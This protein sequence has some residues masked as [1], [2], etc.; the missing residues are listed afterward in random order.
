MDGQE[1]RLA[2]ALTV[3]HAAATTLK[4]QRDVFDS[5]EWST[6]DRNQLTAAA[7]AVTRA[8]KHTGALVSKMVR[9][10][11]ELGAA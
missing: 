2:A 10:L 3:I 9:T 4:E 6:I 11:R 8:D 7:H 5:I 1:H